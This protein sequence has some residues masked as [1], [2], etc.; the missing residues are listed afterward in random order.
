MYFR[1]GYYSW[2]LMQ[3]I[4]VMLLLQQLYHAPWVLMVV[5]VTDDGIK[6]TWIIPII[7]IKGMCNDFENIRKFSD[8]WQVKFI[9]L[10]TR[11]QLHER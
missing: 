1:N 7:Q 4:Y 5:Y 10:N 3:M 8:Q 2:E 11:A 9:P 6:P